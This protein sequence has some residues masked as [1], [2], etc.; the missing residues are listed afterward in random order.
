MH[1]ERGC[2]QLTKLR[3][4]TEAIDEIS[5]IISYYLLVIITYLLIMLT[6]YFTCIWN[7]IRLVIIIMLIYL[8]L[9]K[10]RICEI[11]ETAEILEKPRED[12]SLPYTDF[13]SS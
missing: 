2:V 4:E 3:K 13:I 6:S 1:L 10:S 8:I 11:L 9:L 5:Y 12:L 7:I